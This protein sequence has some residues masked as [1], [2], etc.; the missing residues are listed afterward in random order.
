[1]YSFSFPGR[2][3]PSRVGR[4]CDILD[5]QYHSRYSTINSGQRSLWVLISMKLTLCCGP[6]SFS[7][8]KHESWN[9]CLCIPK[10]RCSFKQWQDVT[11]TRGSWILGSLQS[12]NRGRSCGLLYAAFDHHSFES[13]QE[14]QTNN[15]QHLPGSRH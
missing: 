10:Y 2:H 6:G 13:P 3:G 8:R 11:G 14:N 1:M 7:N 12:Q 9:A 4:G 15:K 5:L